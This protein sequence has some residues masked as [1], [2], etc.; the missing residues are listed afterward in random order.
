MCSRRAPRD[1]RSFGTA[2]SVTGTS[3][4]RVLCA[5]RT[6]ESIAPMSTPQVKGSSQRGAFILPS[7]DRSECLVQQALHPAFRSPSQCNPGLGNVRSGY[8]GVCSGCSPNI[9]IYAQDVL[10]IAETFT[11]IPD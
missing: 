9:G 3:V 7:R 10:R 6:T 5:K 2:I 1:L 8:A 11:R 4:A